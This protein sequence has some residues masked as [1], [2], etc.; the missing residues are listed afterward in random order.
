[1]D[2]KKIII[3]NKGNF[4]EL[5]NFLNQHRK[6]VKSRAFK[7]Y[8]RAFTIDELISFG[9]EGLLEAKK[10]FDK[11]KGVPFSAFA[12]RYIDNAIKA[13]VNNRNEIVDISDNDRKDLI[14]INKFK[15]DF[16]NKEF[17]EPSV[18]QIVDYMNK[19]GNRKNYSSHDID[20]LVNTRYCLS[21]SQPIGEDLTLED[22]IGDDTYDPRMQY[23]KEEQRERIQEACSIL[24]DEEY[25][26]VS[27]IFG[28]NSCDMMD[29]R[30]ISLHL[31]KDVNYIRDTF[32]YAC[33]RM[34]S[35]YER[36][37]RNVQN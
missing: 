22:V 5:T 6:L 32:N 36:K 27:H 26:I 37:K 15:R 24:N 23:Y 7:Y 18:Y 33:N 25:F 10:R 4:I 19:N 8:S 11:S 17:Q 3:S 9:N 30:E 12:V 35:D 1:M 14:L 28:V 2:S 29:E 20:N 31:N 34:K 13:E 21:F 16:V